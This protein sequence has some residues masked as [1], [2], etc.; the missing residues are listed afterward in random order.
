MAEETR[1]ETI[2]EHIPE[3]I[4]EKLNKVKGEIEIANNQFFQLSS[5]IVEL[6]NEL[7]KLHKQRKEKAQV[8][9]QTLNFAAGKLKLAKRTG[10]NWRFN[11]Q[12]SF[13]GV[14]VPEPKTQPEKPEG[15]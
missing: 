8:I 13:V 7:N 1:K 9:Q 15:K 4:Q 6:Q 12:D 2:V 14:P 10:Y 5:N 11:G 3:K